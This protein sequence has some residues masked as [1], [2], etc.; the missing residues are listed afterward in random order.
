M[1]YLIHFETKLADHA[2]HYIGYT[3][4]GSV[5]PRLAMHKNGHGARILAACNEKRIEYTVVRVWPNADRKFERWL[6]NQ[7]NANRFCPACNPNWRRYGND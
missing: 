4:N 1:V 2:Q 5:E 6:K 7:K 3:P